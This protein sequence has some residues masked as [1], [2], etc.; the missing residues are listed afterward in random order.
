MALYL[1]ESDVDA[2]L[3]IEDALEAVEASFLRLAGGSVE[4]RPRYRIDLDGGLMA[5]M[6]AADLELDKAGLKTYTAFGYED[7]RF[8]V[9]VFEAGRAELAGVIE[10]NRLGQLRTGAA[11]GVA[12]KHLARQGAKTL[13]VI[14][15]GFQA[16]TQVAAI[17]AAVPAVERV[18]AYCR[19]PERLERF[20]EAVGAHPADGHHEAG[21]QEIVVTSTTSK[22][23]VLRGDWLVPGA[24]VC[25][26]GANDPGARE[27]DNLVLERA[28]FVCCDSREQSML[29]SGDLIDPVAQGVLDWLEVH[30][31]QEVVAGEL[32]GRQSDEDIV[33]FKS[34]GI[35]AWDVAVGAL[36]LERARER[37]VGQEL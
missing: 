3:T 4:N 37:G 7:V 26:I 25:A 20:C 18:V 17:R 34:N 33:V 16:E 21:A 32:A 31:L 15:C 9:L 24:L 14:G 36:A 6:A 5:V 27:L 8:L 22:D 2:L 30:E 10:A 23:P 28:A 35:A 11:S 12:A 13:G 29:E 1:T 19:T